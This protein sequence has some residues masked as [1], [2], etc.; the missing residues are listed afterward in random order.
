MTLRPFQIEAVERMLKIL[1]TRRGVYNACEMGLGK[2][3]QAIEV[4]NRLKATSVLIIC[5]A[6]MCLVWEDEIDKWANYCK[7]WDVLSYNKA[8]QSDMAKVLADSEWDVLI[9]D[10]AHYI[11][12]RTAKR[13][14]AVLQ[15]I[16]PSCKTVIYLSD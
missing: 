8:S 10:E 6:V 7:Y 9:C 3:A 2:S 13:T 14:K 16:L 1:E 12:N 11:K 4:T 5:P 15:T